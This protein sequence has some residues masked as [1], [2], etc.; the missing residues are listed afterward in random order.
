MR[1]G[2]HIFTGG[3]I[4]ESI[5]QA[6]ELKCETIQIFSRSPR[7]W[8]TKPLRKEEVARFR[9]AREEAGIHPLFVHI[10]Y[11]INLG[12]P[13]PALFKRS[14][15]T[16]CEDLQR[17]DMLGAEYFVTHVGSHKGEGI[18]KGIARVAE[19]L[20]LVLKRVKPKA[21]ILLENTAGQGTTIGTTF[22]E[23][24]AIIEKVKEGERLGLC[25]DTAHAFQAGYDISTRKGLEE[26]VREIDKTI[27]L[28][29]LRLIHANDSKTPLGSRVDRH[30]HIGEGEIGNKGMALIINHPKL[31]GLPFI[32]E[33]PKKTPK[34][35][36]S[37]LKV[38]RRLA[39]S[40]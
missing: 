14:V 33:T 22:E 17:A 13:E 15:E 12:S 29:L 32:L 25:F 23:I 4:A 36:P 20:N 31:R 38:M 37:N 11:L 35:D 16:Y 5:S 2:V 27:G 1:L 6:V 40:S 7:R 34:D 18:K 24:Q 8:A 21:M 39:K 10:P 19:G 30:E 28:R 26:T 3:A 9:K